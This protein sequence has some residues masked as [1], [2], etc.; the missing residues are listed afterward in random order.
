MGIFD[1][2]GVGILGVIGA[3]SIRGVQSQGPGNR[4]SKVL[5]FFGL[6]SFTFQAQVAILVIMAV[7][8]LVLKTLATIYLTRRIL[9]FLGAKSAQISS[10]MISKALSMQLIGLRQVSTGQMQYNVTVGVNAI[11]LGVLGI[12]ST[13]LA[14]STLLLIVT[15]GILAIDP[16][17]AM[18][19]IVIFGVTGA[20]LYYS[21]HRQA[22]EIGISLTKLA[23]ET[24]QEII[25]ILRGYRE[26][27]VR[28]RRFYYSEKISNLRVQ[29]SNSFA[30]Q[31][32]LPYI[33]KYVIEV[34][35]ILGAVIIAA[36]QFVTRDASHAVAGLAIFLAA[37]S[38]LAPALLRLQQ[39][40]IQIQGN[41]GS[42]L[43]ALELIKRLEKVARLEETSNRI[44]A[45]HLDFSPSVSVEHLD[46]SYPDSDIKAISGINLQIKPGDFVAIV[47]E[48]G[49]GK[50]TLIDLLLGI[51]EP[52]SGKI[53]ISNLSPAEAI[54][55]WP[56]AIAYVPQDVF[57]TGKS[58]KENIALGY[59]AEEIPENL[60]K[61]ALEISQLT[62]F[63]EELPQGLETLLGENGSRLSGGQK[64]RIGIARAFLTKPEIVFLDEATSALDSQTE[65]DVSN[66]VAELKGKVTII[67]IAHRLST[68][69]TADQVL[70]VESGKIV[71]HGS[72]E[73]VRAM[74][75]NFDSQ[76]KLMGL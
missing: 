55:R 47:G 44:P 41:M 45:S 66:A 75:P 12:F 24:D 62:N 58:I 74:V 65:L 49:S 3:L 68:V 35:L 11:T 67:M 18:T 22:R 46:F 19:A 48:S 51:H 14:D 37:G 2:V 9:Y 32:F 39:S 17:V 29:F 8:T 53:E 52:T 26:L 21:L 30:E 42:A 38:R 16:L 59:P 71:A 10:E 27:F 1:L 25:E 61:G 34:A 5:E 13:V 15:I 50:S 28:D 64:Q 57:L 7:V 20:F 56:G 36:M 73:E 43:P 63:V 72:F 4:V 23:V 60:I 31:T 6:D 76:A 40:L 69:R 33:S 54:K 70:Y